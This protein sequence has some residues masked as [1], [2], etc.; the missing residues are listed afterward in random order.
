[1]FWSL[2]LPFCILKLFASRVFREVRLAINH[3]V[4]LRSAN[5]QKTVVICVIDV[6]DF[7]NLLRFFAQ[8]F[9]NALLVLVKASINLLYHLLFLKR[10]AHSF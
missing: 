6:A 5:I 10:L 4:H 8:N 1:M 7:L 9:E 2:K 3:F